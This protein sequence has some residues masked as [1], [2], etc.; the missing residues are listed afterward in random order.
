MSKYNRAPL[1][2][3]LRFLFTGE[4]KNY[5][6]L[7]DRMIRNTYLDYLM[8]HYPE[9]K[10]KKDFDEKGFDAVTDF[11]NGN[12][13]SVDKLKP[14]IFRFVKKKSRSGCYDFLPENFTKTK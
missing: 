2:V 3:R 4:I 10:T 8:R 12:K 9:F 6:Y 13:V 14:H 7:A 1:K 5:W 11:L